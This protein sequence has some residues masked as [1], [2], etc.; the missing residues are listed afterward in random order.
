MPVTQS[1]S[2]PVTALSNFT[3]PFIINGH[4]FNVTRNS[5]EGLYP[6]TTKLMIS[7]VTAD[8]NGTR[9]NCT[10]TVLVED[11]PYVQPRTSVATINVTE[12]K[13]GN[14]NIIIDVT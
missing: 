4:S 12:Q 6:L 1:I 8:L 11:V 5:A 14:N 2:V 7:N 10:A 3:S 9:V 13:L